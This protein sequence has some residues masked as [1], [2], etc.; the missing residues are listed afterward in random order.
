M[1]SDFLTSKVSSCID[2]CYSNGNLFPF[3]RTYCFIAAK[4]EGTFAE[5]KHDNAKNRE[6]WLLSSQ[7]RRYVSP[8]KKLYVKADHFEPHS[9]EHGEWSARHAGLFCHLADTVFEGDSRGLRPLNTHD[10]WC[11]SVLIYDRLVGSVFYSE[12]F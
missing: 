3:D 10:V 7:K 4:Y 12:Q 11:V 8:V 2:M 6:R 1:T 5:T 9:I